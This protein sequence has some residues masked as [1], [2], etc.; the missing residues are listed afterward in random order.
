M[1]RIHEDAWA[2]APADPDP[3]AWE[4]RRALLLGELRPGER[5]LD[6]GCGAG[7]F[8]GLAPNGIGVDVARGAVER[9]RRHAADVRLLEGDD[10]PVGHG[11]VSLVWCSEVV[12][13]VADAVGL[14]QEC[15]RVLA[16]GGRILLT[17]PGHPWWRRLDPA[18]F[19]PRS[20]H[21]RF[22]T[23]ASLREVLT[24]AGFDAT[25]RGRAWLVAR[26]VRRSP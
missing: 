24:E 21:L 4:R 8:L 13:H 18:T 5:W 6:L 26:G 2:D 19:D 1:S 14:L 7:R 15:R 22:F 23:R 11:E 12:E 3:W 9:A 20:D 25:V 10:L 17:T 16:P